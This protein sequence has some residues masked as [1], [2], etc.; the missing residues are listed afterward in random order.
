MRQSNSDEK[1]IKVNFYHYRCLMNIYALFANILL[2]V[3][4]S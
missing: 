4:M 2:A 1:K 3:I